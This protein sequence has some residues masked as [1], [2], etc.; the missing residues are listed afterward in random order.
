MTDASLL[1]P[2]SVEIPAP[3][4][5]EATVLDDATEPRQEVRCIVPFL[6]KKLASDPMAWNSV[7]IA[8]EEYWPKRGDRALI[9]AH[10]DGPPAIFEWWPAADATP[11]VPLP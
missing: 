11:D 5:H 10:V 3:E 6:D 2:S 7:S 1:H 4:I 8:R 9:S